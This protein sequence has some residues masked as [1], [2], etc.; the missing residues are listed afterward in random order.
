MDDQVKLSR[1]EMDLSIAA[2]SKVWSRRL[3]MPS[4]RCN[5]PKITNISD[6]RK[7][8][9]TTVAKYPALPH[10]F[11]HRIAPAFDVQ[12]SDEQHTPLQNSGRRL[13]LYPGQIESKSQYHV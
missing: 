3:R 7:F 2:T 1:C 4:V 11:D 13:T 5:V 8:T 6:D 10:I 12:P 9:T